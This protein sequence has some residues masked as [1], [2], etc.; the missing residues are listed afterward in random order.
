MPGVGV[1]GTS[2]PATPRSSPTAA[3][4]V[5]ASNVALHA[6]LERPEGTRAVVESHHLTA[7]GS[8]SRPVFPIEP[9]AASGVVVALLEGGLRRIDRPEG[10]DGIAG[11]VL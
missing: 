11:R 1:A 4:P 3:Y 6:G 9:R 7:G 2:V 5:L 10:C 8:V